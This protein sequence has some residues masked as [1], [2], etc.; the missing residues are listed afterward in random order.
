M[1]QTYRKTLTISAASTD[2]VAAS[3]TP[4]GAG[5]L[6]LASSTVTVPN[7][8]QRIQIISGADLRTKNFVV[9]GTEKNT[10]RAMSYATIGPNATTL[11]LPITF[12]TVTRISV[13]AGTGA[14]LTVG[15]AAA[16]DLGTMP[17][18]TR[19]IPTD[20]SFSCVITSGTPTYTVRFTMDD[21]QDATLDPSDR[22][23][24][25]HP[26]VASQTANNT[27]NFGK[28]VTGVSLYATGACT[29]NFTMIQGGV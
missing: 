2:G 8:G 6:T 9:Y 18:N 16:A 3:Q 17:T 14:A 12:A 26:I 24:F 15:W 1:P 11:I 23:W 13:D 25:D 7:G 29:M 5:D 20:I 22:V 28:P 19:A 4:G 27:G 21:L 10:G